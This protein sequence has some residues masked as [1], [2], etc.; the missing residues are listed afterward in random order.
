M[1][2]LQNGVSKAEVEEEAP[3]SKAAKGK[4]DKSKAKPVSKP[5]NQAAVDDGESPSL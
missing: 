4:A 5:E 1:L 2:K 3:K